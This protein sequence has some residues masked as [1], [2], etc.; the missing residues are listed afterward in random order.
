MYEISPTLS[1]LDISY[2]NMLKD[3]DET[4]ITYKFPR[5]SFISM[6]HNKLCTLPGIVTAADSLSYLELGYNYLSTIPYL[7]NRSSKF[8]L[9][10][11]H[12]RIICDCRVAWLKDFGKCKKKMGKRFHLSYYN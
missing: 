8:R 2:N 10:L 7:P 12:N 5:L 9:G 6:I 4:K 1:H 3:C 11:R